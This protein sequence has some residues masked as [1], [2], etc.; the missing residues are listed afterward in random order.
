VEPEGI[1]VTEQV[2]YIDEDEEL[3]PGDIVG[4]TDYHDPELGVRFGVVVAPEP[5]EYVSQLISG[6]QEELEA[7]FYDGDERFTRCDYCGR[8]FENTKAKDYWVHSGILSNGRELTATG[9]FCG[10]PCAEWSDF[11]G[12]S[13]RG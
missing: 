3:K 1:P 11:R 10:E 4:D 2:F 9:T 12:G 8:V 13:S 7:A 6:E 5:S